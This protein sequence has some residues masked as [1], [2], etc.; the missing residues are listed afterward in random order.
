VSHDLRELCR[1]TTW[2][3]GIVDLHP[4]SS[5]SPHP[6]KV[7]LA[8]KP[9][10]SGERAGAWIHD[11]QKNVLRCVDDLLIK[12]WEMVSDRSFGRTLRGGGFSTP[13]WIVSAD[14]RWQGAAARERGARE[15]AQQGTDSTRQGLVDEG[16]LGEQAAS[17]IHEGRNV[18]TSP[19][20]VASWI[21][22]H[23]LV[24]VE[25]CLLGASHEWRQEGL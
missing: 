24:V 1:G 14:C 15:V 4:R 22:M 25:I 23:V 16:L 13:V 2:P 11:F 9:A 18:R 21:K 7:Q 17:W 8:R 20:S 12:L 3:S 10:F 19:C 5:L 6:T